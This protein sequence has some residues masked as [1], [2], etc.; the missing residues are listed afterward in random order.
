MD[1]INRDK[2]LEKFRNRISKIPLT[3]YTACSKGQPT[4]NGD[5]DYGRKKDEYKVDRVNKIYK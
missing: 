4:P 3:D 5:M 1:R 2:Q